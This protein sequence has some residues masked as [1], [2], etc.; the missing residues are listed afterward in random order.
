M[1]DSSVFDQFLHLRPAIVNCRE[2]LVNGS[3]VRVRPHSPFECFPCETNVVRSATPTGIVWTHK[4]VNYIG[5]VLM[6]SLRRSAIAHDKG[7]C[8]VGF[9]VHSQGDCGV[10]FHGL[11]SSLDYFPYGVRLFLVSGAVR[12]VVVQRYCRVIILGS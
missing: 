8:E 1:N 7:C 6:R 2:V 12:D 3:A 11:H 9:A 5:L 4:L 10:V